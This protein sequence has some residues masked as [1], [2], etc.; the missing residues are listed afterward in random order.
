MIGLFL[1]LNPKVESMVWSKRTSNCSMIGKIPPKGVSFS[2][3]ICTF[4]M[5]FG[6]LLY[7]FCSTKVGEKTDMAKSW[8]ARLCR[9]LKQELFVAQALI[10]MLTHSVAEIRLNENEIYNIY[11]G[12]NQ[13]IVHEWIDRNNTVPRHMLKTLVVDFEYVSIQSSTGNEIHASA[14]GECV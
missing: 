8:A 12:E 1:Y 14:W 9:L 7:L 5:S 3:F 6:D 11:L 2:D 10:K 13:N 4:A